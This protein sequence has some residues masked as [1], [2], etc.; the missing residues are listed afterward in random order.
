VL[1]MISGIGT[2]MVPLPHGESR[3]TDNLD[4][5]RLAVFEAVPARRRLSVSAIALTAGVSIRDCLA[6]LAA[7]ESAQLV[8]GTAGGWR[9]L[10][11]PGDSHSHA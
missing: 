4:G 1:E 3:P 10:P 9:A 7:L 2:D 11:V 6:H 8:E 5:A